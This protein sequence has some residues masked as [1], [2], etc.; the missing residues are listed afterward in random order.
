MEKAGI[1]SLIKLSDKEA[2]LFL[3]YLRKSGN[4]PV[5]DLIVYMNGDSYLKILDLLAGV[6]IKIPNRKNL[7]RDIEHIKIYSYVR[8]RGYNL[9]VLHSASKVYNKKMAFVRRSVEKM[10]KVIEGKVADIYDDTVE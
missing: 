10:S 1:M 5:Y 2:D 8:D 3:E 9:S 4:T 7:Y 6:S